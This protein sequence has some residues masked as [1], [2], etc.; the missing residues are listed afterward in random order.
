MTTLARSRV[1]DTGVVYRTFCG[2]LVQMIKALPQLLALSRATVYDRLHITNTLNKREKQ[3]GP[4]H[5]PHKTAIANS[6]K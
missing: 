1:H 3:V 2:A 4:K 5:L 6:L